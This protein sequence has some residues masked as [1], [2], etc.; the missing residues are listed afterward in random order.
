[1]G[2]A[3][4]FQNQ[5]LV[6]DLHHRRPMR[7]DD[8]DRT[9]VACLLDRREKRLLALGIETGIRLVEHQ[10]PGISKQ[11]ASQSNALALAAEN[12]SGLFSPMRVSYP[13][14][15]RPIMS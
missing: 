15:S 7:D 13:N 12:T 8:D 9:L 1:M 14:G 3:S 11:R 4:F 10:Q 2:D 6:G 5:H